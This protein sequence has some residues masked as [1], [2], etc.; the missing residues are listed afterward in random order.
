MLA[1]D[2]RQAQL[3]YFGPPGS[4]STV[5]RQSSSKL[6]RRVNDAAEAS[7]ARAKFVSAVDVL[8]NIGWLSWRVVEAWRQGRLDNLEDAAQVHPDK[9]A[10][11]LE[12]LRH[13]A[14]GKGLTP[15]E[16]TYLSATRDRRPLRFTA[17]GDAA[18]ERAY[19]THWFSPELSEV[20]RERLAE[21]QNKAP[22]LVVISPVREWTCAGCGGTGDFLIM[23]DSGPLCLTCADMDHL[24]FLPSGD[25]A[26][27]RRAKKASGLSAVVVRFSRSR[28]HYER[29]GILVEE[30]ALE[31]AEEQCLADEDVRARRR[32]RDQDRRVHEDVT[33][34]AQFAEEIARLF[35]GCLPARAEAIAR[36]AGTRGSGR[37]G[38]S[39]AGR[40][41]DEDAVTL[42][43]VASVRHEDTRYDELLMSGVP[44]E[45][46][47]LRVRSDI[48]QALEAWRRS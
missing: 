24:V 40:A 44:R 9:L 47:R 45:E 1:A 2:L 3:I 10:A 15:S 27:T 34:Q 41:L 39:A 19:R 32:E 26:L 22:D 37:V 20:K 17:A 38:R 21:R 11:S 18:I 4:L 48:D 29:Q 7:L 46:A 13:W 31:Q 25:A 6:E 35:P 30:G 16:T 43:V 8:T 28:K 5:S 12:F 14:E 33:F 23:E 36:H 42:A